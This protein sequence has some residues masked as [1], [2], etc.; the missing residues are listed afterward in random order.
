[1]EP[2][3]IDKIIK[4]KILES[5]ELH[6]HEMDSAK[7]FVWTAVQNQ[8]NRK[9]SLRWYHLAAA[10][11]L[12]MIS[13]SFVLHRIQKGHK[14]EMSMLS[15]RIDQLQSNYLMQVDLLQSKDTEIESLGNELEYVGLQLTDIQQQKPLLLHETIVH[16]TDTVYLKQIE[17]ITRVSD[18]VE[19]KEIATDA[20]VDQTEQMETGKVQEIKDDVIFP[21]YSKLDTKQEAETIKFKFGSF[22]ARKN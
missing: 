16:R 11:L 7:P 8:I 12:L 22:I 5:D 21:S 1:M 20:F 15:N 19:S 10:I 13:F 9:R 17:Y 2:K 18:P 4:A 3:D 6:K 14:N